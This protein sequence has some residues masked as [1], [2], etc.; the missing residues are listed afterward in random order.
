M[1]PR[2]GP[3][4]EYGQAQLF[5]AYRDNVP[6]GRIS[7]HIN[8]RHDACQGKGQ[9]FFGFF[10]CAN[11]PSVAAPL[12]DAAE[13]WL[14]DHDCAVMEGPYSFGVYDEIGVLLDGQEH[15]PYVLTSYNPDYYGHLLE[16]CGFQKSVDWYAYRV[17]TSCGPEILTPRHCR[18]R[19]R[20][21]AQGRVKMRPIDPKRQFHQDVLAI[22]K[23]FSSAWMRNWGHVPMSDA[24]FHRMVGLL[25]YVVSPELSMMAEVDGVPVGC[26]IVIRDVNSVLKELNGRILPFGWWKLLRNRQHTSRCRLILMG[27]MEEYRGRGYDLCFYLH[28]AEHARRHGMDEVELSLIVETNR[29]LIDVLEHLSGVQRYKTFRIY[30]R[31]IAAS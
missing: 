29:A 4:F 28:L 30:K 18:I 14:R 8:P 21:M 17:S 31:P 12:F 19:D 3:F 22:K 25:R 26:S 9:G 11:D 20:I 23:I 13:N 1:D 15:D 24:E 5:L 6:V 7:A 27:L 16:S 10:E 2:T